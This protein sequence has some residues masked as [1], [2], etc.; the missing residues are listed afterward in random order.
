MSEVTDIKSR[1]NGSGSLPKEIEKLQAAERRAEM[2]RMELAQTQADLQLAPEL[3]KDPLGHRP[4]QA[5]GD[6]VL[7]LSGEGG[8]GAVDGEQTVDGVPGVPCAILP[9]CG[10]PL[11]R[12]ALKRQAAPGGL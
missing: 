4:L 5:A 6:S 9:P 3:H 2:C 1:K 8:V 10:T 12:T 7:A 11:P